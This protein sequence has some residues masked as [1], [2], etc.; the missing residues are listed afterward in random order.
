MAEATGSAPQ[1]SSKRYVFPP[2][3]QKLEAIAL[4]SD[5]KGEVISLVVRKGGAEQRIACG[6]GVW[7]KGRLA[8]D[9]SAEQPTAASGAWT[10]DDVYTAKLCFY[11]TPFVVTLRLQFSGDEVHYRSESNVGFGSNKAVELTGK[12][13]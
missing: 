7:S 11:E 2:N 8:W 13:E 6:R 12:V 5:D 3:D 9:S 4:E 10:A 1:F